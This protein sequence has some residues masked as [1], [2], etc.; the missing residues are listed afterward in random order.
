[1]KIISKFTRITNPDSRPST[2]ISHGLPSSFAS[3]ILRP[4]RGSQAGFEIVHSVSE[5]IEIQIAGQNGV[6]SV[7]SLD[8]DLRQTLAKSFR[9]TCENAPPGR[10]GHSGNASPGRRSCF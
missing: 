10:G 2:P 3:F 4:V 6:F 5:S 1:M 7:F 8:F 9:A